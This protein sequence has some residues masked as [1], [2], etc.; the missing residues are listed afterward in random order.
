[1]GTSDDDSRIVN[2]IALPAY[3][4]RSDESANARSKEGAAEVAVMEAKHAL[5]EAK[6]AQ[7][8]ARVRMI[9]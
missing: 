2:I 6:T 1:M 9:N 3:L 5:K 7:E 4:V 8:Q